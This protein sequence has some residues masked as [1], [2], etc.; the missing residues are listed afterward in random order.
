MVI[1]RL[2]SRLFTE[3]WVASVFP[4]FPRCG[5]LFRYSRHLPRVNNALSRAGENPGRFQFA[6]KFGDLFGRGACQHGE[7]RICRGA[8]G[9]EKVAI[10]GGLMHQRNHFDPQ[11]AR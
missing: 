7:L 11:A 8:T 6:D 5:G 3:A 9:Y 4:V 10:R 1:R 2:I